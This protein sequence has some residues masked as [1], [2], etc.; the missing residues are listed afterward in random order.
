M[1]FVRKVFALLTI[2]L[3]FTALVTGALYAKKD[4]PKVVK[5]M[6]NPAVLMFAIFGFFATYCALACGG[7]DKKVPVNYILLAIFTF[8]QAVLVGHAM[9]R[10]PDKSVVLCAAV[11]TLVS[12]A[13]LMTYA[14]FTK[15]DYTVLGPAI[16]Q[17]FM[18]FL[19]FSLFAVLFA[20][21]MHYL[22]ACVGVI[23][24][25]LFLVYDV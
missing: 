13:S 3:T 7:L 5:M 6:A 23:F 4:D 12:C 1:G 20:P 18:V 24:F 22:I 15:T 8:C 10:V 9:M 25:G 19:V 21:K 17:A 14:C 11:M 16:F 2:Q